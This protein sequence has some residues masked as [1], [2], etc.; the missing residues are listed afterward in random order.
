MLTGDDPA[1]PLSLEERLRQENLADARL[2][3]MY[4]DSSRKAKAELV[5]R[6]VYLWTNPTKNQIGS[7]FVWVHDG[8]PIVV[9]TIFGHPNTGGR[10]RMTH[11]FHSLAPTI[12]AAD[13]KDDSGQTWEA[14]AAV[15]FRPLPDAPKPEA[16][17]AKRLL[18]MRTLGR[19]FGGHTVDWRKQRW[20]LRLLPQPLFRYEKPNDDAID[21]A[22][23]ALVTS[24]GTDPEVFLLLEAR[25]EGGWHYA[26]LRFSDSSLYVTHKDKAIWACERDK[27]NTQFFN[28]DH[29]YRV[30]HKRFLD[31]SFD[32]SGSPKP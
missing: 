31:E 20:A 4:L 12:L 30:F 32:V 26:L 28:P 21:G 19:E 29:T 24:A 14:K 25:K 22:L 6:P 2:W 7:V 5:E 3:E 18:Q 9:G 17:A 11:E 8:R 10:R 13:C 27:A 16:T 23:L 15:T 1:K